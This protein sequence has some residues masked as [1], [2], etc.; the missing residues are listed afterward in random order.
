MK[1]T[2]NSLKQS[3]GLNRLHLETTALTTALNPTSITALRSERGSAS[4]SD[5]TGAQSH[6]LSLSSSKKEE[7]AGERRCFLSISPLSDYLP[8]RSSQGERGKM[9]QVFCVPNAVGRRLALR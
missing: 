2:T 5:C 1:I 6:F 4:R 9:P 3:V 7:R 8:A